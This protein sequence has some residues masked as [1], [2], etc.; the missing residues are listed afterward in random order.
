M[1]HTVHIWLFGILIENCRPT[2]EKSALK[3]PKKWSTS[4]LCGEDLVTIVSRFRVSPVMTTSISLRIWLNSNEFNIVNYLAGNPVMSCCG[5][6]NLLLA[7]AS[8]NFDRCHSLLLALSAAGSARKRPHFDISPQSNADIISHPVQKSKPFLKYFF[9][10]FCFLR[11]I[12][13]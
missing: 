2:S 6:Q 9:R 11:F 13:S 4:R 1:M 8:P 10:Y 7:N 3:I 5:A 12:P